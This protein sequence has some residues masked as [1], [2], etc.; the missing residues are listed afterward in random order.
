MDAW[1]EEEEQCFGLD[2][3]VVVV[4]PQ[5]SSIAGELYRP[6]WHLATMHRPTTATGAA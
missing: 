1:E 4:A 3:V 6:E 2:G 5:T